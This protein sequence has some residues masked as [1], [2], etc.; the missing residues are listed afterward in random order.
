ML[1]LTVKP[2]AE[3]TVKVTDTYRVISVCGTETRT[4]A[5][6]V[7]GTSPVGWTETLRV[8]GVVPLLGVAANHVA[9]VVTVKLS[10]LRLLLVTDTFCGEGELPPACAMK[11]K[12]V[13][14]TVKPPST[15]AHTEVR[16]LN[17]WE[18]NNGI[19]RR[20]GCV[21]RSVGKVAW[22]KPPG[23]REAGQKAPGVVVF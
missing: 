5:V 14:D 22:I 21:A 8:A 17:R 19:A 3:V 10:S 16:G 18:T 6:Y 13:G 7:P 12:L 9:D 23:E 15:S 11:A 4:L 20:I 1:G 2:E